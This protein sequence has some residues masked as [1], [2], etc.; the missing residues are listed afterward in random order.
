MLERELACFGPGSWEA[1]VGGIKMGIP[2]WAIMGTGP[3]SGTWPLNLSNCLSL[4]M[5]N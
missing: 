3:G 5:L 1:H 4:Y 2:G